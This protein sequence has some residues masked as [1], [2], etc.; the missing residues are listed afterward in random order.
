LSLVV[1]WRRTGPHLGGVSASSPRAR[2]EFCV[3]GRR[4]KNQQGVQS[5]APTVRERGCVIMRERPRMPPS[6]VYPRVPPRPILGEGGLRQR[7]SPVNDRGGEGLTAGVFPSRKDDP[8]STADYPAA[9]SPPQCSKSGL[10]RK[11]PAGS[12]FHSRTSVPSGGQ[13]RV[14]W[15]PPRS[16]P[17]AQESW[18]ALCRS[19][20]PPA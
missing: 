15:P 11:S 5:C 9:I 4:G 6:Q 10:G 13:R 8:C 17:Q 3:G 18:P 16:A 12:L 19:P 20:G 2:K 1:P 14:L 7:P